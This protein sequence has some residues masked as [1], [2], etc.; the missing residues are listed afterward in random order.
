MFGVL[1]GSSTVLVRLDKGNHLIECDA[2]DCT[3]LTVP[4]RPNFEYPEGT[5]VVLLLS[6]AR[7]IVV[8]YVGDDVC[9]RMSSGVHRWFDSREIEPLAALLN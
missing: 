3:P 7:G 8:T 6:G 2:R 4:V 5:K 1:E 9:L